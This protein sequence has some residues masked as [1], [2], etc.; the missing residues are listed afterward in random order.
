MSISEVFPTFLS[1]TRHLNYLKEEYNIGRHEVWKVFVEE[2]R[3][4]PWRR[5]RPGKRKNRSTEKR[6]MHPLLAYTNQPSHFRIKQTNKP[7]NKEENLQ[8]IQ[9]RPKKK[10]FIKYKQVVSPSRASSAKS[11]NANPL[12]ATDWGDKGQWPLSING[13]RWAIIFPDII[14]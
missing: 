6:R 7:T 2:Q 5:H 9:T 3:L 8:C 12:R 14:A 11:S 13:I 1:K 10:D 4:F